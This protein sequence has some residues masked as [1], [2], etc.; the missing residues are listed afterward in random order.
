MLALSSE[1]NP[2][3]G[4]VLS[5]PFYKGG[6]QG[7]EKLHWSDTKFMV[8]TTNYTARK[9]GQELQQTHFLFL[10]PTGPLSLSALKYLYM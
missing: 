3:I 8:F 2:T 9:A 6:N 1:P 5:S 4:D 10:L 7:S